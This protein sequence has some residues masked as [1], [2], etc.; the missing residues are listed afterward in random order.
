MDPNA[1]L[2]EQLELA[3]EILDMVDRGITTSDAQAER[4]AELVVTLDTW[5]TCG[6]FLPSAWKGKK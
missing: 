4:L 3:N 5:L 2:Q 6:G 1:N